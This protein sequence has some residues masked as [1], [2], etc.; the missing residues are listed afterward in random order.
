MSGGFMHNKLGEAQFYKVKNPSRE[1]LCALCESPRQMKYSRTLSPKNYFQIFVLSLTM[2][3]PLFAIMSY[4]VVYIF[5]INWCLFEITNKI[6]YRREIPCPH[7]GFDAT[8][9]RRDVKVAKRIVNEF[10]EHKNARPPA[11]ETEISEDNYAS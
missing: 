6:L 2:A 1:F 10:W 3:W 8:W 4:K 7:C 9:Y 11:A 5:F